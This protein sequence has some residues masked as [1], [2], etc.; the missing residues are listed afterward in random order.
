M[1]VIV[2]VYSLSYVMTWICFGWTHGWEEN[3]K[4]ITIWQISIVIGST[5]ANE[6]TFLYNT[7]HN[8]I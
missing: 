1:T 3:A 5:L 2:L 7:L 4:V 8:P 6:R